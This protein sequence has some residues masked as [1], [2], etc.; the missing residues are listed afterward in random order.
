MKPVKIFVIGSAHL[1]ILAEFDDS[2][3]K[4]E[5][6]KIG[7]SISF[8]FGGTA[9]NIATHLQDLKHKPFVLTSLNKS[10][11]AGQAI[12]NAFRA[13]RLSRKYLIDEP[14]LPDSTFV[15]AVRNKSLNFAVSYMSVG[16]SRH[17]VSKLERALHKF[18]WVVFDCNLSQGVIVKIA[19][20]CYDRKINLIGAATSETKAERLIATQPYGTTALCMNMSEA[21]VLMAASS[22]NDENIIELRN[23]LNTK[24]LMV[25]EGEK[26]WYLIENEAT[27]Y[28]PPAGIVPVTTLGAG[29][30]ACA[31]LINALIRNHN[32]PDEVN[33]VA[34][35]ALRSRFPSKFAE[36]TST[37]AFRKFTRKRHIIE[38]SSI[39]ITT[40]SIIIGIIGIVITIT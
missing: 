16:E 3:Q 20:I 28:D 15:G 1:D 38:I 2:E 22:I 39:V 8:S 14:E 25:T 27:H 21:H 10:S 26:G 19:E 11:M 31:G 5:I 33:G 40:T 24:I 36:R 32:I 37:E 7:N 13:G 12:L 35:R 29:D 30:A 34:V 23:K 9:L 4:T 6:D 17:I 18:N